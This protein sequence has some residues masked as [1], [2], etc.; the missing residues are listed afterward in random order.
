MPVNGSLATLT[1]N[2]VIVCFRGGLT[3][4]QIHIYPHEIYYCHLSGTNIVDCIYWVLAIEWIWHE[5]KFIILEEDFYQFQLVNHRKY[6]STIADI[7]GRRFFEDGTFLLS[8]INHTHQAITFLLSRQW[9]GL[10]TNLDP[11]RL[12]DSAMVP[13]C[14]RS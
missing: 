7:S 2:V 9:N 10:V 1:L 6:L 3:G 5:I 12:F 14:T 11:V 4:F 13:E 8:I